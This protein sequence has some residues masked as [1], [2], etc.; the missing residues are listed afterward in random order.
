MPCLRCGFEEMTEALCE[1]DDASAVLDRFA[2]APVEPATLPGLMPV[3]DRCFS[4]RSVLDILARLEAEE[5]GADGRMGGSPSGDHAFEIADQPRHRA[6]QMK[7]GAGRDFEDCMRIE[8][9]IVNRVVKGHEFFE[10]VR[11]VIIDKDNTPRWQPAT[12]ERGDWRTDRRLFRTAG[13]RARSG[14]AGGGVRFR[15]PCGR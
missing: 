2:K 13:G 14:G 3:I 4:A 8:Y 12:L 9:R 6:P 1:E 11:A 7:E 5:P 10:G 15:R